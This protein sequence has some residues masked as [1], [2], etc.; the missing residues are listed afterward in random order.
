[1]SAWYL[2]TAMGFYPIC[3]GTDQYVLGAPYL[4]Y[5]KLNLP[6][7]KAFE[8]KAP[9]VSDINRYVRAV[10]LNGVPYT[11]LYIT[12]ADILA[13]GT[14]EFVMGSKPD[15]RR[16]LNPSD[17]PYSASSPYWE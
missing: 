15:K 17:K 11:K 2:F 4:P 12:H 1:M 5:I 10:R 3:P 14:L 13:G 16:G 8:I 9:G 7:G 6:N